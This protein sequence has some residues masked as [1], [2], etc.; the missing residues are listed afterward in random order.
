[1]LDREEEMRAAILRGLGQITVEEIE[2]PQCPEGGLLIK[3][4]ACAICSVDARMVSRGQRALVYPRIPGHEAAGTVVESRDQTG[5]FKNGDRVQVFPGLFC[6]RC[7]NCQKGA[8]NRCESLKIM[9]FSYDGAF[10]EYFTVPAESVLGGGVN[11]IPERVSFEE[12]ALTEPLASC[13]NGQEAVGISPSDSVLIV[14][15]GPIGLLQASL[16]KDRGAARIL[17][18]ENFAGR[19]EI[20][21]GFPVDRVIDT[22]REDLRTVLVKETGGGVDVILT[23]CADS[24][25]PA[26]VNCLNAGGRICLF[27]GLPA[28]SSKIRLEANWVH[29]RELRLVG[30][31]GSTSRQNSEALGLIAGGRIPVAALIT[32]RIALS[33]A[34]GGLAGVARCDGLK[35][36]IKFE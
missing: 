8:N 2:Q 33:L 10:A 5:R 9:G 6:G 12:A 18:A 20:P 11:L 27:C 15:A 31:Y 23:A 21:D 17:V 26:L 19:L 13:L 35:T 29:Y 30:A 36:I 16:A 14:G 3:T 34:P 4:G 28:E 7:V 24:G 1:L 32:R 22:G 25:L